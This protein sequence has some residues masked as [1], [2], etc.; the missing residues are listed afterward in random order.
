MNGVLV[1]V[2]AVP[3]DLIGDVVY[4]DNGVEKKYYNEK[5]EEQGEIVK[6]HRSLPAGDEATVQTMHALYRNVQ[7]RIANYSF[8]ELFRQRRELKTFDRIQWD[9][10][11]T[12]IGLDHYAVGRH[13]IM[14]FA[15]LI[16]LILSLLGEGKCLAG[17]VH[18]VDSQKPACIHSETSESIVRHSMNYRFLRT[19]L[20]SK[21][22]GEFTYLIR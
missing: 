11:Q 14:Q 21:S 8:W 7:T 19:C 16:I 5:N 9:D 13:G 12:T 1:R 2:I 6:K 22:I 10:M 4:Y 17:T 15:H 20:K 3:G 18:V